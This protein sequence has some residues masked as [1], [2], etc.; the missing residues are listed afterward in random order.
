MKRR[1]VIMMSKLTTKE[2]INGA[3]VCAD[4]GYKLAQDARRLFS[5]KRYSTATAIA[6][7]ALEEFGKV[8]I[9]S[10][11]ALM[12]DRGEKIEWGTF[13]KDWR[14]HKF[15][16]FMT[17]LLDMGYFGK[18]AISLAKRTVIFEDLNEIREQALYVDF[19]DGKWKHPK[20]ISKKW[21]IEILESAESIG[22]EIRK[23]YDFKRYHQLLKEIKNVEIPIT[24]KS[25]KENPFLMNLLEGFKE[26]E[27]QLNRI[28]IIISG[29]PTKFGS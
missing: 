20:E 25:I 16:Q 3:C 19:M 6:I 18:D 22:A 21:T 23:E 14:N 1:T 28:N 29:Y 26:I 12:I 9:L 2:A 7:S 4:N 24:A 10:L 11:I 5:K 8:Y 17:G 27:A 15:K 13:W